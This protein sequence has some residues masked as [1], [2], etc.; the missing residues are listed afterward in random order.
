LAEKVGELAESCEN[1]AS[2]KEVI[3]HTF[4]LMTFFTINQ[5]VNAFFIAIGTKG[6]TI[7]R[8]A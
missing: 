4:K 5:Q 1:V 6:S 3:R 7:G 2:L 8:I